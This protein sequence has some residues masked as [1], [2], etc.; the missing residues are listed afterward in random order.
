MC[1]KKRFIKETWLG[2]STELAG[3]DRKQGRAIN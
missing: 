3:I 2:R 1:G